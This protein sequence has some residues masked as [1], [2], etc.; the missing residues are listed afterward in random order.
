MIHIVYKMKYVTQSMSIKIILSLYHYWISDWFIVQ[1]SSFA[2]V[3][4]T[5]DKP[6]FSEIIM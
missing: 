2:N 1:C 6:A 5:N 4:L 3:L